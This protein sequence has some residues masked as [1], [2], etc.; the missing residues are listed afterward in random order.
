MAE[1]AE[2]EILRRMARGDGRP[3]AP[4]PALRVLGTAIARAA[5]TE[6]GLPVTLGQLDLGA[7][8]L[9]D[10]PERLEERALMALIE[11]PDGRMGLAVLSP[12]LVAAVIE[13]QTIGRLSAS[14]PAARRPTRTDAVLCVP[15]IE[16]VLRETDA[17]VEEG[18]GWNDWEAAY[19]YSSTIDDPRLLALILDDQRYRIIRAAL[20]LGSGG[21][22]EGTLF[23]A[24]PEPA[25]RAGAPGAAHVAATHAAAWEADLQAAVLG[26][27]AEIGA[28]LAR[29]ERPLS[30]V[31]ALA[32]GALIRLPSD[33][34]ARVRVEGKG[35]R[36]LS[37]AKLG[38]YRG[39]LALRLSGGEVSS[40][41]T[42]GDF[43]LARAKGTGTEGTEEKPAPAG[44]VA[45]GQTG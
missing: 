35:G 23:L 10:L 6:L 12:G 13:M 9:A 29:V 24:M 2:T 4:E 14:D 37:H 40:I 38:Q 8:T 7:A 22:R 32:P 16:R 36:F 31:L 25:A 28:V 30:E 11:A 34:L 5:E 18:D 39:Y 45:V 33:A 43:A 3:G 20:A 1:A 15:W 17:L 42:Q 19:R 27:T 44:A 26:G 21:A 41:V